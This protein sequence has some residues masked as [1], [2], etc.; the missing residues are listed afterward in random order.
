[1]VMGGD[2]SMFFF[3]QSLLFFFLTKKLEFFGK[4]LVYLCVCVRKF[5]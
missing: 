2:L 4:M 1:M 3:A 5:D